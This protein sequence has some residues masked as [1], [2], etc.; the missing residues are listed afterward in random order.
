MTI[1]NKLYLN[2]GIVLSTVLVLLAVNLL[3]VR[4]EHE[5][6]AAAQFVKGLK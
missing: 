2:F 6:K 5:I 1:R 3:A 4:R